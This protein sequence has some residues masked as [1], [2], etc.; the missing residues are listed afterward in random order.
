MQ[1]VHQ[2]CSSMPQR[3]PVAAAR[4]C[5]WLQLSAHTAAAH[6]PR[7]APTWA[8]AQAAAA[9]AGGNGVGGGMQVG[10]GAA[11]LAACP[12]ARHAL[13]LFL[14]NS[15]ALAGTRYFSTNALLRAAAR[16]QC[17]SAYSSASCASCCGHA[18]A[19][20]QKC[21][22][23][24]RGGRLPAHQPMCMCQ[25]G[26]P[27]QGTRAAA[28]AM[29]GASSRSFRQTPRGGQHRTCRSRAGRPGRHQ[30]RQTA[31]GA[32]LAPKSATV[33][34]RPTALSWL[35][36]AVG[37]HVPANTEIVP[38]WSKW[39]SVNPAAQQR[40]AAPGGSRPCG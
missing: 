5:A 34:H 35:G 10:T 15:P 9:P 30:T 18:M 36:W 1:R 19:W 40:A 38:N 16:W 14:S 20:N 28:T 29:P 25:Q 33:W 26:K 7:S 12:P 17:A 23:V 8:G 21:G 39:C 13:L 31:W 37:R 2:A 22:H 27:L 4:T 6:V 24:G 32:M 11:T 3:W